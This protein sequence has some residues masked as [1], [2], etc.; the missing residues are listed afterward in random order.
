MI[1]V[2][3]VS[4]G[5]GAMVWRLAKQLLDC[6]EVSRLI[7][8][9]NIPEVVPNFFDDRVVVV[10]NNVPKGFGVNHNAAFALSESGCFC[11]MNPDI[12]LSTNPFQNLLSVLDDSAV[13]L[14][15]PL[16]V[17]GNGNPE[18]SMRFFLSPWSLLKRVARVSRGGYVVN[19]GEADFCPDW[20]AGMFML[21]RAS[22]YESI[23]GFDER[24]FMYCEDADICTR[25]WKAGYK[26][27]GCLSTSVIH[28]AH[29]ASHRSLRHL[30]WHLRSMARYFQRHTFRLP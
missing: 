17:D 30:M 14:V 15:A 5:H 4:H 20:V 11:V 29:R 21:F 7:L 23:E 9:I 12:E 27:V 16:V 6:S 18:D 26:V 1:A 25:L 22:A 28:R 3:I 13:G 10:E 24:Y 8:T 19:V 2:S